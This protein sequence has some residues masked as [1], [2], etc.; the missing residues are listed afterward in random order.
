MTDG[1]RPPSSGDGRPDRPRRAG[2]GR[3]AAARGGKPERSGGSAG[4]PERTGGTGG[5]PDRTG[6]PASGGRPSTGGRPTGGGRS[7]GGGRSGSDAARGGPPRE[8]REAPRD[9]PP[10]TETEQARKQ[11]RALPVPDDAD[12]ADLDRAVRRELESLTPEVAERV[13][14]H[15]VAAGRLLD[16]DPEQA[17]AHASAARA[18]GGR[19]GVVREAAGITA[20][21]AGHYAEALAE[22]RAAR[23]I[24]GSDEHLPL[25]ADAERG[26]GRPER[27]LEMARD[28]A[29]ARLP[30]ESQVEM[31]IVASG[32]RRDLGQPDAAVLALQGP[33]LDAKRVEEWTPRLWYAYADA[34]LAAGR[35]DEAR[36]WFAKA[37]SI[38][39]HDE[40]DADERLAELY[41]EPSTPGA[42]D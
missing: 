7:A 34:L 33:L 2:S 8:R 23:R 18:L 5:K 22:L 16:E 24:T 11:A 42:D 21:T 38:D 27:A 31:L 36:S 29:V 37:A 12:P 35:A 30:V 41:D 25:M 4:R 13:A 10:L 26:L 20:Y 6:R 15:L 28:P 19:L 1:P 39:D 32:A 3:P 17:H 40:T 14:K 9:R